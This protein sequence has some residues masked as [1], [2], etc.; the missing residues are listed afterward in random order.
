MAK[1]MGWWHRGE[2][3]NQ[4]RREARAQ[5]L[6]GR[7]KVKARKTARRNAKRAQG[8]AQVLEVK[9]NLDVF[10]DPRAQLVQPGARKLI[11]RRPPSPR[12]GPGGA[13]EPVRPA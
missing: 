12:P 10:V 11:S 6:S 7:Q 4:E 9:Q 13:P 2:L 1:R 3:V 5:G 8:L